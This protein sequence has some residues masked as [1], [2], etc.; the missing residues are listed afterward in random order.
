MFLF[1]SYKRK[2]KHRSKHSLKNKRFFFNLH[3]IACAT[4]VMYIVHIIYV[5]YNLK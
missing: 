4:Y 1:A 5:V 2:R 3:N